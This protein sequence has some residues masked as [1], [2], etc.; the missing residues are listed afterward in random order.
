[1]ENRLHQDEPVSHIFR[2]LTVRQF[3]SVSSLGPAMV[4]VLV[5]YIPHL[6]RARV[7]SQ[8]E[9]RKSLGN[10]RCSHGL[11]WWQTSP[12]FL[13]TYYYSMVQYTI[14]VVEATKIKHPAEAL[15]KLTVGGTKIHGT[16][17]SPGSRYFDTTPQPPPRH[18]EYLP[19]MIQNIQ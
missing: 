12:P 16:P 14:V 4:P 17:R 15:G 1:M 5:P 11:H 7:V 13:Y 8:P 18:D 19:V 9:A 2:A 3:A 6:S 10:T